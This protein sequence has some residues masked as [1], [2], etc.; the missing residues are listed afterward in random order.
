MSSNH[1]AGAARDE[2]VDF[3][4]GVVIVDMLFVHYRPFFAEILQP[5][6]S[7]SDLA[8]EG[9][10][11][12]SGYMTGAH[13]LA[14]YRT[15]PDKTTHSLW[16]RCLNLL[17]VQYLLIFTVSVPHFALTHRA[18]T[19]PSLWQFVVDSVLFRNQVGL[20]HIL[21]LFIAL[22]ALN[23]VMLWLSSR[24]LD[25][26]LFSGSV[27]AFAMG[28]AGFT[29]FNYGDTPIFPLLLW[30]LYYVIGYGIGTRTPRTSRA[31]G[32]LTPLR[33]LG[34]V[35]IGLLLKHGARFFPM[36]PDPT[37]FPLSAAGVWWGLSLVTLMILA[38]RQSWPLLAETRFA[39]VMAL[40]GRNSLMMFVIHVYFAK[41]LDVV[42]L[43]VP[44]GPVLYWSLIGLN[45][46][47]AYYLARVTERP[48]LRDVTRPAHAMS[49]AG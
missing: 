26:M 37:K 19:D 30:Q 40:Y 9:F 1:R 28:R 39:R 23:P 25:W 14:R 32:W 33:V 43:R 2:F 49:T 6:L 46:V 45:F 11:L 12:L 21:P 15:D 3:V 18:G 41:A 42:A 38:A 48:A 7:Y 16:R 20:L 27:V 24:G 47:A 34:F 13:Y 5:A 31:F 36:L 17:A 22:S 4:R 29:A 10:L 8:M 44:L 35:A